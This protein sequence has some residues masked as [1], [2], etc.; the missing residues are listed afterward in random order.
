MYRTA[1]SR[2]RALKVSIIQPHLESSLFD[3]WRDHNLLVFRSDHWM[4]DMSLDVALF[5]CGENGGK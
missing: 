2:V 1:A 4:I 3:L 5:G